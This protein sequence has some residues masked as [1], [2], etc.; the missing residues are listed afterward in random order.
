MNTNEMTVRA[1]AEMLDRHGADASRWPELQGAE[2]LLASDATAR[3]L[4]KE[5]RGL[6]ELLRASLPAPSP[7]TA[8]M[9]AEIRGRL[10]TGR[11]QQLTDWFDR[12]PL[13]R[14]LMAALLPLGLGFVLGLGFPEPAAEDDLLAAVS[15]LAFDQGTYLDESLNVSAEGGEYAP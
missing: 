9:R 3:R 14:P 12:G 7:T 10:S 11:W 8:R 6:E 1:F 13:L 5:A 15:L 2:R 4:L